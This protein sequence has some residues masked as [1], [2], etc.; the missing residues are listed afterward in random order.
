MIE[1]ISVSGERVSLPAESLTR[2]RRRLQGHLLGAEHDSYDQTRRVW[3]AM[4]DRHPALIAQCAGAAD[5]VESIRFAREHDLLV[6]VR[7]GGHGVAG[8][9]VHDDA[10]MIDLSRMKTVHVDPRRQT[11]QAEP[12]VIWQEF[13]RE[14]QAF[15]LATPGGVVGTTGIAGL[16]LGGG[17]G[18]LNSKY[19]LTID[20]L[21]SADVVTVDGE[22]LRADQDR[23]ADLFWGLRGAGA[24]LG[25]VTSFEYALHRVAGIIGG[26]VAYPMNAATHV[27]RAYRDFASCQPD[28]LTTYAA[29]VTPQD[30]H[31]VVALTFCYLGSPSE[32]ASA[33]APLRRITQPVVDTIGPMSY[34]DIQRI[35]TEAFPPGRLGYW[36]SGLTAEISDELIERTVEYAMKVPSPLSAIVFADCHGAY[37]RVERTATAYFHR[38]MQY[39]LAI[40]SSW[41][42]PYD[43][44]RNIAWTRDFFSAIEP[45]VRGGVYV[46]DLGDEDHGRVKTAYGDNYLRLQQLKHRYD[47]ENFL[48]LNQNIQPS[49]AM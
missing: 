4:I 38:D 42:Q 17:Q 15:G 36:K 34:L 25:I 30:G 20:N 39:D 2:F 32:A 3:N 37:S 16:T 41:E 22:C 23:N 47:P 31:Q 48:R 35:N 44:D 1:A 33:I 24:N 40:L 29:I 7:G 10:L 13:D 9:A 28:E 6:S 18:W 21:L 46:N 11:A 43:S 19:G 8:K 5:V 49:R 27:L 26:M 45:Y 14:T 12:G